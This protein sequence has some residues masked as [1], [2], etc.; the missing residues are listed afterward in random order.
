M[1]SFVLHK[2]WFRRLALLRCGGRKWNGR[3]QKRSIQAGFD[4]EKASEFFQSLANAGQSDPCISRF[5]RSDPHVPARCRDESCLGDL[6]LTPLERHCYDELFLALLLQSPRRLA[7]PRT[8]PF[9]GGN[10][11]SNPVGDAK[12]FQSVARISCEVRGTTTVQVPF[13]LIILTTLL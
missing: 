9:H 5:S 12:S 11:G 8:S 6:T 1:R 4:F 2:N 7:R 10:T 13:G 3:T